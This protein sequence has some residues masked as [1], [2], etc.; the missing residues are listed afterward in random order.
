MQ[1]APSVEYMHE[2][3]LGEVTF[4][5]GAVTSPTPSQSP[6][7]PTKKGKPCNAN[8]VGEKSA[9]YQMMLNHAISNIKRGRCITHNHMYEAYKRAPKLSI[10]FM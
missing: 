8:L 3:H 5:G 2:G 7:H 9:T 1:V 10:L 6:P 4:S